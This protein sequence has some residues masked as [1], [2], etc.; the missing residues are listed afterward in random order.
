MAADD[1]KTPVND[2]DE[3]VWTSVSNPRRTRL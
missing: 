1:Q 3:N 2:H